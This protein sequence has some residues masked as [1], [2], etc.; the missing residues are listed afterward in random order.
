MSFLSRLR[1]GLGFVL[2]TLTFAAALVAGP[3]HA[4]AIV[5]VNDNINF[6]LGILM[7]PQYDSIQVADATN[8]GIVGWQENFLI[9]RLRF[10]VGGQVSKDV[11]FFFDTENSN[12]GKSTQAIGAA[13]GGK[14][15]AAGFS[16][17]DAVVEWRIAKEFNIMAGAILVPIGREILKSSASNFGLDSSAYNLQAATALQNNAGRDTG[18]QSRGYYFDDHLE[19]RAGAYQGLRE[20]ASKNSFRF[21]TRAQWDFLDT[22]VYNMPSYTGM[23]FG[24]KKIVALGGSFD[25]QR[26]YKLIASDLF[27]DVP[28]PMGSFISTVFVQHVDGGTLLPTVLQQN[29][30]TL[31]GGVYSKALKLAGYIRYEQLNFTA[32]DAKNEQRGAIGL[33]YYLL[34]NNYNIKA[35]FAKVTPHVG[36]ARNEFTVQVQAYYF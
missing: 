22:E 7:Q 21:T 8:T 26:D 11:F 28:I 20:A 17:L 25:R 29:T 2:G 9:R 34:G 4:Q 32:S 16:L 18:V 3:A 1:P 36:P 14:N 35:W 31:E 24:T 5:K 6:K 33:N 12:L 30:V 19:L 13:T 10:I 23:N 15:L 27:V